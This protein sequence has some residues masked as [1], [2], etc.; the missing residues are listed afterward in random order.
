[1]SL[2]GKVVTLLL[3]LIQLRS[4]SAV[5]P[6]AFTDPFSGHSRRASPCPAQSRPS[7]GPC[8]CDAGSGSWSGA[9]GLSRAALLSLSSWVFGEPFCGLFL[10]SMK[11]ELQGSGLRS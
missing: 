4:G 9:F 6:A 1:M 11:G 7:H 3:T 10:D 2:A 5:G 8:A